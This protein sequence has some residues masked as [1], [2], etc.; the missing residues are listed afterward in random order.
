MIKSLGKRI[1]HIE[2]GKIVDEEK[3]KKAVKIE[4]EKIR[5]EAENEL[6][7]Q[8][9]G[10]KQT[11][12]EEKKNEF[13]KNSLEKYQKVAISSLGGNFNHDFNFFG[14]FI[15][16][17]SFS[18]LIKSINYFESKPQVTAFF[19]NEAKQVD[20]NHIG[21]SIARQRAKSPQ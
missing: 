11:E 10:S 9:P 14:D 21:K 13:F 7:R 1:I 8:K 20:I 19:K 12:K 2:K 15:F 17:F 6:K 5:T 16:H 18:W 4:E 3:G